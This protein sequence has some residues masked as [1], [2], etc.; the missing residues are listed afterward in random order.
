MLNHSF[1]E[2]Y[3]SKRKKSIIC[4]KISR[5]I[6]I[7]LKKIVFLCKKYNRKILNFKDRFKGFKV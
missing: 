3:R 4:K 1:L 7:V 5:S 2:K 6:R